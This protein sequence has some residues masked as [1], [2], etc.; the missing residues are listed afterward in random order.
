[1]ISDNQQKLEEQQSLLASE[2]E[3]REQ[4]RPLYNQ[5]FDKIKGFDE[6]KLNNNYIDFQEY[7]EEKN[8]TR[9]SNV[10]N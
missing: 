5:V 4:F 7:K 10:T 9:K 1:M 6:E 3:Y 8:R 2:N